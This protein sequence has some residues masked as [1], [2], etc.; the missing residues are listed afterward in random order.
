[1][2][3]LFKNIDDLVELNRLKAKFDKLY[4]S[5]VSEL[6]DK[7][8]I[9]YFVK[10][11]ENYLPSD[12]VQTLNNELDVLDFTEPQARNQPFT[13]FYGPEIIRMALLVRRLLGKQLAL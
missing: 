1:M 12:E 3:D 8:D 6:Q 4:S 7:E 9:S 11:Y 5:K 2:D 10:Q 13:S